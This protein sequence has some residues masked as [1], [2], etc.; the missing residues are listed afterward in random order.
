[1][2]KTTIVFDIIGYLF[3]IPFIFR[4]YIH[5]DW[6]ETRKHKIYRLLIVNFFV[7]LTWPLVIFR[8]YIPYL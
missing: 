8:P 1:M 4:K 5:F 3:S 6:C 7:F 2:L